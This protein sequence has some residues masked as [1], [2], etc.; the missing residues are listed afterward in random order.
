MYDLLYIILL[1]RQMIITYG[2][3]IMV[4]WVEMTNDYI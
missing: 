4:D 2:H 3:E 1:S